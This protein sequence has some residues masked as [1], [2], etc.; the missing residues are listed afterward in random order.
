[1]EYRSL[2]KRITAIGF[3]I[4][5]LASCGKGDDNGA[6]TLEEARTEGP[7]AEYIAGIDEWYTDFYGLSD[8][9]E[10]EFVRYVPSEEIDF[11]IRQCVIDQGFPAPDGVN[12]DVPPENQENMYLAQYICARQYAIDE[13]Y[14]GEWAEDQTRLQYQWTIEYLIPCL[15]ERGHPIS[16]PPSEAVFVDGWNSGDSFYP[17][18]QIELDVPSAEYN[19]I[20]DALE[21]ECPQ[22]I[23]LAIAYGDQTIEEWKASR[24]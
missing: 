2:G 14:L 4:V 20:W 18:Q 1:M 15:E 10:V 12:F 21:Q 5:L 22:Q 23:P 17:F 13:K 9:P 16:E 11:V 3:V 8:L 24:Q 19:I 6:D 7:S